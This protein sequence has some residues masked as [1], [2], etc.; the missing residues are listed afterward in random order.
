MEDALRASQAVQE[1]LT[2]VLAG[3]TEELMWNRGWP[4]TTLGEVADIRQGF[5]VPLGEQTHVLGHGAYRYLRVTDSLD[6]GVPPRFTDTAPKHHLLNAED[7]VVVRY[8]YRAGAVLRGLGGIPSNNLT[9]VRPKPGQLHQGFLFH[10]LGSPS[11]QHALRLAR[12][13]TAISQINHKALARLRVPFP[14]REDQREIAE[15]LDAVEH[16][17]HAEAAASRRLR[18]LKRGLVQHWSPT[19]PVS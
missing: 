5:Q 1:Q 16:N 2:V 3:L 10:L 9:R 15:R 18:F 19:Q 11:T 6:P 14:P 17:K 13:A 4:S 7:V 8:G 12:T